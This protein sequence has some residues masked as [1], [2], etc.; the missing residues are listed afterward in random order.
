[1]K[2]KSILII[3]IVTSIVLFLLAAKK[4]IR[5]STV[6]LFFVQSY[7]WIS[8]LIVAEFNL[9]K[10]PKK[11]IFKKSY[12]GSFEFEHIVFPVYCVMFNRFYPHMKN[13]FI[14]SSYYAG[15]TSFIILLE[16]YAL[17]KTR[18][19]KLI[20]WKLWISALTISA[21]FYCSI[22]FE[23]WVFKPF[24]KAKNKSISSS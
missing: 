13:G 1:M 20:H 23:K 6:V 4:N 9:I 22:A 11:L 2:E 14:K 17:K 24:D 19:I 5:R 15:F 10:Y 12:K 16:A 21:T 3:S 8:G 18:S 7:A